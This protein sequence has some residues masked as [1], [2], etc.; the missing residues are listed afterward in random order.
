MS[1]C[2]GVRP[3]RNYSHVGPT[4][5]DLILMH[6]NLCGLSIIIW[7]WFKFQHLLLVCII[8]TMWTTSNSY[9]INASINKHSVAFLSMVAWS[10]DA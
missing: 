1:M 5:P 10:A 8:S 6:M 4:I 2:A 9:Y 3:N 7:V